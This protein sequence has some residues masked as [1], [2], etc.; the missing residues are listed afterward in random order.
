MSDTEKRHESMMEFVKLLP[1]LS[2]NDLNDLQRRMQRM[3]VRGL[4][5]PGRQRRAGAAKGGAVSD[6]Q[7]QRDNSHG[8][9]RWSRA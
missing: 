6:E 9:R 5:K 4:S 8:L 1:L 2:D 3:V 7:R